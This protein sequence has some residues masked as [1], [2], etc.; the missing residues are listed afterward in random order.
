M[1]SSK[2]IARAR[3]KT[4]FIYIIYYCILFC[5]FFRK[6]QSG[7]V[8]KMML[9]RSQRWVMIVV[10]RLLQTEM[11]VIFA[12]CV[13]LIAS[14]TSLIK[15]TQGL[16]VPEIHLNYCITDF[17]LNFGRCKPHN[18]ASQSVF[19]SRWRSPKSADAIWRLVCAGHCMRA[20]TYNR[21]VAHVKCNS[22]A[23]SV[24]SP[25]KSKGFR[26]YTYFP[27]FKRLINFMQLYNIMSFLFKQII[28]DSGLIIWFYLTITLDNYSR[29]TSAYEY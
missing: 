18:G 22:H 16:H 11:L 7:N 29:K 3:S 21:R 20:P 17:A 24:A 15:L 9:I 5:F 23:S 14:L 25:S 2:Y 27:I 6:E 12:R 10:K 1:E 19:A 13:N 8:F 26:T 28:T 4:I